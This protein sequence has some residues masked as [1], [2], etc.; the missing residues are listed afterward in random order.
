MM[1]NKNKDQQERQNN[2]KEQATEI[3]AKLKDTA[4]KIMNDES[5]QEGYTKVKEVLS[6]T[7]GTIETYV[8]EIN[9]KPQVQ[10]MKKDISNT[11][12]KVRENE[13]VQK[14]IKT[15]KKGTVQTVNKMYEFTKEHFDDEKE[16]DAK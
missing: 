11:V 1:E 12:Q 9:E 16:E 5:V 3:K 14:G 2:F 8:K 10:N 13:H 6:N 15:I 4:D 7:Y